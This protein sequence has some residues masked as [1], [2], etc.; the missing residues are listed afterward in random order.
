MRRGSNHPVE[1]DKLVPRLFSRKILARS[2]CEGN[3]LLDIFPWHVGQAALQRLAKAMHVLIRCER[4]EGVLAHILSWT[5]VIVTHWPET[6]RQSFLKSGGPGINTRG[7][8][9]NRTLLHCLNQ[10]GNIE[11]ARM[12]KASVCSRF[13]HE[14][15]HASFIFRCSVAHNM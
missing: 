15:I 13:S 9:K 14:R 5:R 1:F 11:Q 3:F 7:K 12:T 4:A 2:A 8:Q 6:H 10:A